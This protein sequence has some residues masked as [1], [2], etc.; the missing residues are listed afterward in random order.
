MSKYPNNSDYHPSAASVKR[1]RH[2]LQLIQATITTSSNYFT[3]GTSTNTY[4]RHYLLFAELVESNDVEIP[5]VHF[6]SW[7]L[8]SHF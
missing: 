5:Y 1:L 2:A 7:I 4:I 8:E 6:L 3:G